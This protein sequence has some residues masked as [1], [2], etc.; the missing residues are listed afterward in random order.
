MRI[1]LALGV[2]L[3]ASALRAACNAAVCARATFAPASAFARRAAKNAFSRALVRAT[4]RDAL[5]LI[6][7]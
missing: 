1:P 7:P 4:L 2:H 6:V 5:A 3:D